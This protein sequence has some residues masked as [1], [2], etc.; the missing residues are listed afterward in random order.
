MKKISLLLLL[1]V[2]CIEA[3]LAT[4]IDPEKALETANDFWSSKT[5][6]KRTLV[7][8]SP[9]KMSKS[10]SRIKLQENDPQYYICTTESGKGFVIVAGEDILS[11]IVGY[12]TEGF[13]ENSE[14]PTTLIEW[15]NEYSAYVDA[16]RSGNAEAIK[17]ETK[18]GKEAISPM[19]KTT[20]NQLSPYN[21]LCPEINGQKTPTGCTATAMAQ[22]MKFHEWPER[23]R[24]SI[25]WANNITGKDEY[26]NLTT[27]TYKWSNM[28]DNYRNGYTEE[29]AKEVAQLMV[30]IGKAIS[31]SYS[32]SGTGSNESYATN[33][34]VNVFDYSKAVRIVKRTDSTEDEYVSIIRENLAARKP[35]MYVGC[36]VNYEGGHAFVCDGIDEND[37]LHIDWGWDGAYNGYFDMTYMAPD[38]IGTGGGMGA[39]NVA[40]AIIVNISPSNKQDP[41]N[42]APTL[43]K[44]AIYKP[45]TDK[46][47]YNYT[48]TYS[49]N[50]AKIR[51]GT[52]ILNRSHSTLDIEFALAVEEK[53][54]NFRVLD[55]V[56][57]DESLKF[58]YYLGYYIDFDID[59]ENKES[60][61]YFEKGTH[62]LRVVH[63]NNEGIYVK[64]DGDQNRL[65]LD[66]N[67]TSAKVYMALP[68]INVSEFNI[69]AN[70]KNIGNNIRFNA[71][72]TNRNNYN[73]TIIIAPIINTTLTDGTV[74]RD[75]LKNDAKIIEILDNRDIFVNF[76]TREYFRKS[77]ECN[78]TF[79]YNLSSYYT[80][81]AT[82]RSSVAESVSGGSVTFTV[83][84]EEPG[85]IPVVTELDAQNIKNGDKM[86]ISAT[87]TNKTQ[88]N[89]NYSATLSLAIRDT[90]SE[91]TYILAQQEN[92]ELKQ[93][94]SITLSYKSAN[95]FPTLPLGKYEVLVQELK[96][97]EWSEIPL[98]DKK[99]F[100][101]NN[102]VTAIP[103]MAGNT[104]LY[105]KS[106]NPGDKVSF[107]IPLSSYNGTFDGFIRVNTMNGLTSVLRSEYTPVTINE[108]ETV[109]VEIDC[110][111]GSKAPEGKWNLAIKY[112]DKEKKDLGTISHNTFGND[113]YDYFWIGEPKVGIKEVCESNLS[114]TIY[115]RTIKV[116]NAPEGS[117]IT[118]YSLDGRTIYS[119]YATE[120]KVDRGVY[121]ITVKEKMAAPSVIKMFVK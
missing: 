17:K 82:Y 85:G 97:G 99:Y 90:E 57:V 1:S 4:P 27:H 22:I 106:I 41:N 62:K 104:S 29:Q 120:A 86:E 118:I 96:E 21:N 78:I 10:G 92:V 89:Y 8:K 19:L 13:N 68:D 26:I 115:D 80:N 107:N 49:D 83:K 38:G 100:Y 7:L 70:A 105:G 18:A 119:G 14:M 114:A 32:L 121:I 52:F 59:I 66:V 55:S 75:T 103:Y 44:T 69:Q 72:F 81:E 84:D 74:V 64:M 12:S 6:E 113:E 9:E 58:N 39:Y 15:L 30:D 25:T 71:K 31:S 87:V 117:V 63:K 108:G 2:L 20:W 50:I 61:F 110:N 77:G 109:E 94:G 76:K 60:G 54:G 47:I 101:I 40:Q 3:V 34:F 98:D 56:K 48:A 11:P 112:Y 28:L 88:K 79:A 23:P 65:M 43:F 102:S 53:D 67:D 116:N 95:Y 51:I 33:A 46:E 91:E 37:L 93:N 45:G 24:K 35:V 5:K 36:G 73:S 111:C 42:A 16:V